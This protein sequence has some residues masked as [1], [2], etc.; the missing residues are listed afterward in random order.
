MDARLV[1]HPRS[2]YLGVNPKAIPEV[3]KAVTAWVISEAIKSSDVKTRRIAAQFCLGNKEIA[4]KAIAEL[5]EACND[6]DQEVRT[7]VRCFSW[8]GCETTVS[9]GPSDPQSKTSPALMVIAITGLILIAFSLRVHA[10]I[11]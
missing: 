3:M 11:S 9:D 6:P 4:Q 2:G 8:I 5:R 10:P 7:A 1:P